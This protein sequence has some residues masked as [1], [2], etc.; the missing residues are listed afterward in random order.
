[1][2]F[3]RHCPRNGIIV[4]AFAAAVL[5]GSH[6]AIG[7]ACMPHHFKP[8]FFLKTMGACAF[9]PQT[10]SFA[11]DPVQQA[12]CLLRSLDATRNL[13][14]PLE[15]LPAALSKR[16]GQDSGLPSREILNAY[17]S[18]QNLEWDFAAHLWQPVSRAHGDDPN[19]PSARYFV[20]HDTS[21][22]NYGHRPFPDDIDGSSKINDLKNFVCWDGWGTAHVIVNRTGE[23]LLNHELAIPWRE[24]KFEQAANFA[25]ALKG[26]FLHFE[27]IQPRRSVGGRG[28]HNDAQ[29]PNPAFTSAQYDRLALLYVI[30]SVRANQWLIPA[31]HAAIDAG[32]R[33][34]HDDPLNFDIDRFAQ[35]LQTLMQRLQDPAGIDVAAAGVAASVP[36]PIAAPIADGEASGWPPA[37]AQRGR[38]AATLSP[39]GDVANDAKP[40][41]ANAIVGS[42]TRAQPSADDQ[43]AAQPKSDPQ[44]DP[45]TAVAEHCTT[46]VV[47]RRRRRVC[48]RGIAK[49][50]ER[51]RHVSAVRSVDRP[52]RSVNMRSAKRTG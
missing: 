24:T 46:H 47:K 36:A 52:A 51:R 23:M 5:S 21:G 34:G 43:P 8:P 29:T 12:K 35:S 48:G 25:G 3:A 44:R 32:I 11:G 10:F 49:T 37:E 15:S 9:N 40:T 2:G 26:L 27:L 42:I 18:N 30:A 7:A 38:D 20:M 39:P 45:G 6:G 41:A 13:A 33:N 4:A 17:L 50:R 28:R 1:M 19:F 16:I 14:A 31:F 22:P